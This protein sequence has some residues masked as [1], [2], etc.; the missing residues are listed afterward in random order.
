MGMVAR[1]LRLFRE[2]GLTFSCLGMAHYPVFSANMPMSSSHFRRKWSL[3]LLGGWIM[4]ILILGMVT[5]VLVVA[6]MVLVVA[7]KENAKVQTNNDKS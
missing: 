1:D 6:I 5:L 7:M 4:V 2:T 3:G